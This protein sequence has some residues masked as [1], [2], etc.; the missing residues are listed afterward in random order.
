[1]NS[2]KNAN[3]TVSLASS[4][5]IQPQESKKLRSLLKI[6]ALIFFVG[7][8]IP[9]L[10]TSKLLVFKDSYSVLSGALHLLSNGKFIAF[11]AV[12]VFGVALPVF[13]FIALWKITSPKNPTNKIIFNTCLLY[14]YRWLEASIA[15]ALIATVELGAIKNMHANIG[16]YL[17]PVSLLFIVFILYKIS[18][19]ISDFAE[20]NSL[21]LSE[22]LKAE[23]SRLKTSVSNKFK[24]LVKATV[25]FILLIFVLKVVSTYISYDDNQASVNSTGKDLSNREQGIYDTYEDLDMNDPGFDVGRY[26]LEKEKSGAVTFEECLGMSAAKAYNSK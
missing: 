6:S 22:F 5:I 19:L 9:I 21:D 13:K 3:E 10:T 2:E 18:A 24:I 7:V 4:Q 17:Y 12:T 23:K 1:M 11:T 15:A 16:I 14:K 20:S 8:V 26:C 25:A